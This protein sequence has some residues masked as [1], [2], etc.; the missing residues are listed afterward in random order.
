MTDEP[1]EDSAS[2]ARVRTAAARQQDRILL[3]RAYAA[4][5][6]GVFSAIMAGAD[7]NAADPTTGLTALHIAVGTNNL[8]LAKILIETWKAKFK[9]DAG[10]RW[11][12]LIAA[13]ARVDDALS[14][15]IVEAEAKAIYRA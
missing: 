1:E 8:T 15:Y 4:D 3:Q 9:P 14:D 13:E 10:G 12:T 11:P 6:K 5:M 7:V 2:P